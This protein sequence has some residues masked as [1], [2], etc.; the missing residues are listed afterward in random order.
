VNDALVTALTALIAAVAAY[1]GGLKV[2]QRRTASSVSVE[3]LVSAAVTDHYAD[4]LR[5]VA[6]L[7]AEVAALT[8]DVHDRDRRIDE[9]EQDKRFYLARISSLESEVAALRDRLGGE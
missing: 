8:R 5:E 3:Q 6:T 9:L 2:E 7:R 1:V 4:V